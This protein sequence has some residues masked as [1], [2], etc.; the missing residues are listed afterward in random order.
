MTKFPNLGKTYTHKELA[1][2]QRDFERQRLGSSLKS[3]ERTRAWGEAIN[4]EQAK[5]RENG[6]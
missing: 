5:R 2:V 3:T 6:K 1:E 4:Q